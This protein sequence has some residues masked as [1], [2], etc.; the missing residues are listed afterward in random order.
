[1]AT[2]SI[3]AEENVMFIP[4]SLIMSHA[5]M[6]ASP[7]PVLSLMATKLGDTEIAITSFLLMESLVKDSFWRPYFDVLPTE[8][9]NLSY[10]SRKSLLELGN[11]DLVRE[12][13]MRNTDIESDYQHFLSIRRAALGSKP[14]RHI[15]QPTLAQYRWAV[16]IID[17][18]GE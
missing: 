6:L 4:D 18:R 3:D 17:S 14:S 16:S 2:E 15:R 8:V 11:D 1:M 12:T 13:D 9:P 7:D 5:S 10:F